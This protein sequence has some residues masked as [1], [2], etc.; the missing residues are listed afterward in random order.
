MRVQPPALLALA[1]G[2]LALRGRLQCRW[3]ADATPPPLP[4]TQLGDW[5]VVLRGRF[6]RMLA[7]T[8][9]V[10]GGVAAA[11]WLQRVLAVPWDAP[12]AP[13]KEPA[14]AVAAHAVYRLAVLLAAVTTSRVRGLARGLVRGAGQVPWHSLI[15]RGCWLL[16]ARRWQ[17]PSVLAGPNRTKSAS[18]RPARL[19]VPSQWHTLLEL[20]PGLEGSSLL[21][22][23]ELSAAAGYRLMLAAAR[24]ADEDSK[25]AALASRVQQLFAARPA[26]LAA[27]HAA[28]VGSRRR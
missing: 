6:A 7:A 9:V 3:G 15:A 27:L 2:L 11:A 10:W 4:T 24:Q 8:A 21:R 22:W 18:P 25:H 23:L 13:A 28:A 26:A 16:I 17:R 5:R 19:Q 14:V 20:V 12:G 1:W